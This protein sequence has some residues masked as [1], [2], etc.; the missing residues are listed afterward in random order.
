MLGTDIVRSPESDLVLCP[1][2]FVGGTAAVTKV[3]GKGITVTYTG[4]GLVTLTFGDAQGEFVGLAGMP[5]FEATTSA[6]VKGHTAVPGAYNAATRSVI[7]SITNA[8]EALH[9]LAALEWLTC[10]PMFRRVTA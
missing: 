7:L 4:T 2:R 1:V 6:N 10:V 8:S 5:S 9:D 3:F